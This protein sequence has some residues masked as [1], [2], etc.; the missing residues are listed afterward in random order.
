MVDIASYMDPRL[1]LF[2]EAESR[3]D[4]LK[5][6]VDV[7]DQAGKLHDKEAFYQAVL[8]REK[9]VSTGIGMGVAFP[10]AKLPGYEEFFIAI[11][12]FTKGIDWQSLDRIPIRLI[13]LI[14]GPSNKQTEYLQLLSQLT[15]LIK[16]EP[17]RKKMLTLNAPEEIIRLLK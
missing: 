13:F 7:L 3:E 17:I 9:L 16:N 14:G 1:V 6:L 2:S 4:A 12:V 8:Q 11:G 10:H 5:S 15:Q